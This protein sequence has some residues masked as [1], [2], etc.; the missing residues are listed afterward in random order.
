MRSVLV[1]LV[2]IGLAAGSA[3]ADEQPWYKGVPKARQD[4]ASELFR[5]GNTF[6]VQN[7]YAKAAEL[8][9][10]ALQSWDHPGIRYNLAVSMI[11]LDR[12]LEAHDH[13]KAAMQY[14]VA[15]LD[16]DKFKDAGTYLKL[17]ERQIVV[18]EVTTEQDGVEITFDGK[19]LLKGKGA[20]KVTTLPG[21]HALV[22][23]KTGY[24]T[25]TKN[26]TLIGGEPVIE[27]VELVPRG[28]RTKLER[29]F[30]TWVPW[31]V[32]GIGA[33][34]AL[35][36]LGTMTLARSH[37]A[38]FEEGFEND[39]MMGCTADDPSIDW[40]LHDRAKLEN[41][42]GIGLVAAGGAAAL[43]GLIMI[44]LNQPREV[45]VS[46]QVI[47]SATDRD[48]GVTYVGRW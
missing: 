27:R 11:R 23:T 13:L 33:G 35:V 21:A 16:E 37:M 20:A 26:L 5:K 48:V 8:Y 42:I 41:T 45:E 36:G 6:F 28:R 25:V 38:T 32:L 4:K 12:V 17:V 34:T 40:A 15:G 30:R 3:V 44:A 7:E 14:G 18:F 29:R 22:A 31:T 1:I 19:P 43:T 2:A 10:Q 24:E 47:V 9:A 39:C 46:G